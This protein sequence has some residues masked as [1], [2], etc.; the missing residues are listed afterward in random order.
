MHAS[1]L[2]LMTLGALVAMLALAAACSSNN[3]SNSN[4]NTGANTAGRSNTV[5]TVAS[6][7]ASAAASPSGPAAAGAQKITEI[8][9]D[10]KGKQRRV[11][12]RYA[13]PWEL[14]R[15]VPQYPE[16]LK[17][18]VNAAELE[19]QANR[20]SDTRA[21]RQMQEAKRRLF[22]GLKERRSA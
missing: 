12:R 13:T 15:Q 16:Y 18:G 6:T 3:N 20:L 2:H 17:P 10:N 7:P 4:T 14:L 11:Y 5:A 19:R 8:T 9:T 22:A 1:R 21:A